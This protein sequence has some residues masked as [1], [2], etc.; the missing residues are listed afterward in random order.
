M[1][2][3]NLSFY[4]IVS[5][6]IELI[7]HILN[8]PIII[9][10]AVPVLGINFYYRRKEF[11]IVRQRYLMDCIDILC[12]NTDYCLGVFRNNWAE[13]MQL[14][15]QFR[16]SGNSMTKADCSIEFVSFDYS[17]FVISPF[18]RLKKLIG[19]NIFW[20]IS[21]SLYAFIDITNAFINRDM[22]RKIISSVENHE[23][24]HINYSD[25]TD[26]CVNELQA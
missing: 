3:L 6:F 16:D 7:T 24:E 20:E 11:E 25:I 22:L 2:S 8:L 19:N 17:H 23:N 12:S 4:H 14:L 13:S 10:I 9:A 5:E 15:K 21:Q 18:Y 1:I 26:K